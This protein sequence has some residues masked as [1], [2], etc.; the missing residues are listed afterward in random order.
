MGRVRGEGSWVEDCAHLMEKVRLGSHLCVD[1]SDPL[2]SRGGG[3]AEDRTDD[4]P[5]TVAGVVDEEC[6]DLQSSTP[7][8]EGGKVG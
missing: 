7:G 5:S 2:Q 1:V 6:K 3:S 4:C 8:R